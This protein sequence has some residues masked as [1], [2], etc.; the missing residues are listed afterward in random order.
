VSD[1]RSRSEII[2]GLRLGHDDVVRRATA[3]RAVAEL[4]SPLEHH[5]HLARA[6]AAY[7]GIIGVVAD[8]VGTADH[9]AGAHPR[10]RAGD[11]LA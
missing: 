3:P 9:G 1:P 10:E 7:L 11:D 6:A 4:S 8:E 2:E 5:D